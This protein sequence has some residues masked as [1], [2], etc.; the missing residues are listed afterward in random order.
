MKTKLL[1]LLLFSTIIS[2]AQS[3]PVFHGD[4]N[5]T[6]AVLTSA[7]PL[8]HSPT[9]ANQT[10]TFSNLSLLGNVVYT[11]VAPTTQ[12]TTTY[13]NST[14]VII[15]T[16]ANG[17]TKMYTKT[18]ANVLSIT[19]LTGTDL[20]I[21]FS[22]N[23]ATLGA[24]PMAYGF[25]NTD[26]VAGNYTYTTYSGT[27]SGTLVTTVDAS[28]TLNLA[29]P[30]FSFSGNVVR[31]K[32]VLNINLNYSFLTNV[33]TVT[34]TSYIYYVTDNSIFYNPIF[35]SITTAAL[36]PLMSIDQT[37]TTLEKF[38]AILDTPDKALD[39]LW[40]KNP[41]AN[42][43][44][45][46]APTPIDRATISVTDLL[47]KTIYQSENNTIDGT[48]EIPVSLPKGI[49]L[50]TIGNDKGSTTKKISKS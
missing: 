46:N 19:G 7:S 11:Y 17:A 13:P 23:N 35:R 44:E 21:N 29:D 28:G 42:T 49:Y 41:V 27:F 6:F 38:Q 30:T 45:I 2:R 8:D 37:D 16:N 26:T 22:T 33:G 12:E 34:Q 50:I 24:F 36:V 39:K 3:I 40:V 32:T 5:S 9:G 48:L 1:L 4:N 31:L 47:G 15:G 10:W 20:N 18:A 14:E 25:S 43:I